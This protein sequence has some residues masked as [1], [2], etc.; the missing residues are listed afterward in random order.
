MEDLTKAFWEDIHSRERFRESLWLNVKD[1]Y[2]P[3]LIEIAYEKHSAAP[4]TA[5]QLL[6][7]LEKAKGYAFRYDVAVV[8]E[9]AG[10]APNVLDQI[11]QMKEAYPSLTLGVLKLRRL[12]LTSLMERKVTDT[13]VGFFINGIDNYLLKQAKCASQNMTEK[14]LSNFNNIE[15]VIAMMHGA[16]DGF[17]EQWDDLD[18]EMKDL[19]AMVAVLCI[20]I[21]SLD[22]YKKLKEYFSYKS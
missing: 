20:D 11:K 18:S 12:W 10:L 22:F 8:E 6:A 19:V 15:K 3:F 7:Y 9:V 13:K 16:C 17:T 5:D 21:F 1:K 14:M 4:E 2:A